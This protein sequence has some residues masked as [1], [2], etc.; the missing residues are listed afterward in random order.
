M[1]RTNIWIRKTDRKTMSTFLRKMKI[2][3]D[4][5]S[6][7]VDKLSLKIDPVKVEYL[8][9]KREIKA[10]FGIRLSFP[11]TKYRYSGIPL[12]GEPFTFERFSYT[13]KDP[14]ELEKTKSNLTSK[15]ME[16]FDQIKSEIKELLNY[17][18][19]VTIDL[20]EVLNRIVQKIESSK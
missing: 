15:A 17:A 9:E 18:D 2:E 11:K 6:S 19:T 4:L 16:E 14:K 13:V 1:Q 20:N 3:I 12:D 10:I 8:P 7:D 5:K